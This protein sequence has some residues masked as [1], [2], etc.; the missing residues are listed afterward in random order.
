M[1]D[2]VAPVYFDRASDAHRLHG[3]TLRVRQGDVMRLNLR[4][5]LTRPKAPP[6][7]PTPPLNGF[8]HVADSNMHSHGM[9]VYPGGWVGG[10]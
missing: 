2:F 10:L 3:P 6:G 4:N 8:T 1:V 5:N 9:H 7:T